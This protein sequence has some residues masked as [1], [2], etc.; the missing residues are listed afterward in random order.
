MY[1][2][3]YVYNAL[4]ASTSLH[5]WSVYKSNVKCGFIVHSKKPLMRWTLV[6]HQVPTVDFLWL[7]C[8]GRVSLLSVQTFFFDTLLQGYLYAV[9]SHSVC[10]YPVIMTKVYNFA[11]CTVELQFS[12]VRPLLYTFK[13]SLQFL[14]IFCCCYLSADLRIICIHVNEGWHCIWRIVFVYVV[15]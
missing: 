11:L 12:F 15:R 8:G 2:C 10:G 4:M 13:V 5:K 7:K 1:V 14:A 6:L 3:M 9:I